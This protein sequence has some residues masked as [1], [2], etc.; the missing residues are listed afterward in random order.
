MTIVSS[1]INIYSLKRNPNEVEVRCNLIGSS[2]V[3]GCDF[4]ETGKTSSGHPFLI[5]F[6]RAEQSITCYQ[7]S[8]SGALGNM[9]TTCIKSTPD[10]LCSFSLGGKAIL[11][12]YE[13]ETG[14][15]QF[16]Q[17]SD[18]LIVEPI[19]EYQN[20]YGQKTTGFTT[21]KT[22]DYQN[23]IYVLAYNTVEGSAVIYQLEVPAHAPLA[24]KSIWTKDWAPGWCRFALFKMAEENLF[25]K[26]NSKYPN[27][28][29]EHFS[30]DVSQGTHS[31]ATKLD[32]PIDLDLVHAFNL[33]HDPYFM[34]YKK[35]GE[36]SINRIHGDCQD[37]ENAAT[38][39]MFQ[40]LCSMTTVELKEAT[41]LI[42]G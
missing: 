2:P 26:T 40:D 41:L 39:R 29:I 1:S 21:I 16:H 18:Q 24:M 33:G 20:I 15:F 25:L 11:L 12:A 8:D 19:H 31:V 23:G 28:H 38:P 32:L 4:L 22:F 17:I 37:W 34:T 30:D 7:I 35:S 3:S 27:V 5:T 36:C 6:N 42:T 10:T 13:S 14:K 9:T